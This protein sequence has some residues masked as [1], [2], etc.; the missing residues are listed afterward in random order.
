MSGY[1]YERLYERFW[2]L[3]RPGALDD[4]WRLRYQDWVDPFRVSAKPELPDD[5]ECVSCEPFHNNATDFHCTALL[6]SIETLC[7]CAKSKRVELKGFGV[8]LPLDRCGWFGRYVVDDA[9]HVGHFVY[10]AVGDF[11]QYIVWDA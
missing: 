8:L 7:F 4:G 2:H 1:I 5:H 6:S 10:D 9:V 3:I 11:L